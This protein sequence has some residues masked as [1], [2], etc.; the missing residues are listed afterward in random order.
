MKQLTIQQ[1]EKA[2]EFV[3][4]QARP[5]DQALFAY[6]FEG[7]Q[8]DRQAGAVIAELKRFQNGDGGSGNAL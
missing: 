3:K 1:F 2:A 7:R 4:S 6:H 8:A 5:L